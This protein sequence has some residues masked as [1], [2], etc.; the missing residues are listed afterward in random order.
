MTP[1]W[2]RIH[3]TFAPSGFSSDLVNFAMFASLSAP[4]TP[5]PQTAQT[6]AGAQVFCNIGCALCHTPTINTGANS[7]LTNESNVPVNAFSDFH[8]HNMGNGLADHV[9]QG[10]ANGNQ[11]RTAPLW[12]VGTAPILL[13]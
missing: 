7:Y 6:Q 13:A 4:P 10:N 8:V 12:G 5:A 11:F 3:S 2:Q 1:I 9:S